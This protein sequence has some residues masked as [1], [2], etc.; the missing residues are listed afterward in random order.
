MSGSGP[1]DFQT[2]NWQLLSALHYADQNRA[3]AALNQLAQVYWPPIYAYLRRKGFHQ[4]DAADL[5]QGFFADVVLA[6]ELLH[7]ARPAA[8]RLRS[9][10]LTALKRFLV[11]QHRRRRARGRHRFLT[12]S[13]V[14]AEEEAHQYGMREDDST[15]AFDRRWAVALL[16][17][18]LRSC[19]RRFEQSGRHRHWKLFEERIVRPM[20]FGTAPPPIDELAETLGFV[21]A[22]HATSAL[23]VVRKSVRT[24][25]RDAVRETVADPNDCEDEIEYIL[26]LLG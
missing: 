25:L 12:N 17:A 5:T 22:A 6:R 7:H 16:E 24:M 13:S 10:I 18:S 2:T 20:E 4:D 26:G 1:A 8:T 9:L 14:S 19:Q 15:S 21:S 11:D 3:E 23:Q